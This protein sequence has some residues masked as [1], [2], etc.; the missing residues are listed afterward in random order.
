MNEIKFNVLNKKDASNERLPQELKL[1]DGTVLLLP[2]LDKDVKLMELMAKVK[3]VGIDN[4]DERTVDDYLDA[5]SEIMPQIVVN[6]SDYIIPSPGNCIMVLIRR[7]L[8]QNF[9]CA[10]PELGGS[11]KI[12]IGWDIDDICWAISS[13]LMA[14]KSKCIFPISEKTH[15]TSVDISLNNDSI[16]GNTIVITPTIENL[17][18][19]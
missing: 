15:I 19:D 18:L 14:K 6:L 7:E 16:L 4:C 8:F 5:I 3:N 9:Y 11:N 2:V 1:S 13:M 12:A 10:I 17:K